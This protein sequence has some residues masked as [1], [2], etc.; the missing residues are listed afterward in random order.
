MPS[1]M[2]YGYKGLGDNIYQRPFI[3]AAAERNKVFLRTPWPEIYSDLANVYFLKEKTTLRTQNKNMLRVPARMWAPPPSSCKAVKMGYAP[4]DLE[5]RSILSTFERQLPLEGRPFRFD[6]PRYEWTPPTDRPYAVV[7][8]VTLRKEWRSASRGPK[9]EYIQESINILKA[10]G[11]Y[12]VSIADVENDQE[13]F[14]EFEPTGIDA[15]YHRGEL[16]TKSLMACIAEA[17]VVVS[18][19]CFVPIMALA[20]SRPLFT[21]FGGR[22]A[23]NAPKVIF[24]DRMNLK[25]SK[26]GTAIPDSY[27]MCAAADHACN[28]HISNFAG[29]FS[30]WLEG[31]EQCNSSGMTTKGTAISR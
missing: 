21:I 13:W 16:L 9:Q 4:K 26:L 1:L 20:Y 5:Q 23:H 30:R 7:R 27:C 19:V 8:P 22:G 6:L 15:K 18:G 28:K 10:H 3:R 14:D 11:Y 25:A 17:S 24:E 31:L 29:Q 12:V 2:V